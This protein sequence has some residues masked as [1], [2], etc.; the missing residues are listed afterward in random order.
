[1]A[2][3]VMISGTLK[4]PLWCADNWDSLLMVIS[5]SVLECVLDILIICSFICSVTTLQVRLPSVEVDSVRLQC[6]Y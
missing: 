2:Q 3:Y 4:M 1:M 6:P 5:M